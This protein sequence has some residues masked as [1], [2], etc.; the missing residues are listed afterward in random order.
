MINNAQSSFWASFTKITNN[1]MA[2]VYVSA[3]V[4]LSLN[5]WFEELQHFNPY[6]PPKCENI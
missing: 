3:D 5:S 2:L 1:L 6:S 4:V